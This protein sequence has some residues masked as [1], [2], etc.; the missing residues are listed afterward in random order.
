[1]IAYLVHGAASRVSAE[2]LTVGPDSQTHGFK[3][4]D[5]RLLVPGFVLQEN[6]LATYLSMDEGLRPVREACDELEEQV[7]C[8]RRKVPERLRRETEN[9]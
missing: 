1:M 5:C 8:L 3:V 6:P 4:E 2:G 7:S 9:A